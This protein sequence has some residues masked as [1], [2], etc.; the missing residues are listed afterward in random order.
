MQN[1]II[2][3]AVLQCVIMLSGIKLNASVNTLSVIMQNVFMLSVIMRNVIILSIVILYV[4]MPSVIMLNVMWP[5]Q[6]L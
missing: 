3:N 4:I 2:L 5:P 6:Q 1:V